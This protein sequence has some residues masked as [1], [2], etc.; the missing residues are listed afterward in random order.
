[1][2]ISSRCGASSVIWSG[3]LLFV[4]L[5]IVLR[6]VCEVLVFVE[7]F[8]D[9]GLHAVGVRVFVWVGFCIARVRLFVPRHRARYCFCGEFV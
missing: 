9:H 8:Y 7:L 1:M 5:V 3:S 4:V 6:L 2:F